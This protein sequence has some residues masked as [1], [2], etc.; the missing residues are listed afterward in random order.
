VAEIFSQKLPDID[1]DGLIK[2][3]LEKVRQSKSDRRIQEM[4][5]KMDKMYHAGKK[6]EAN[7]IFIEIKDM[8]KKKR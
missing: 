4:I 7:R 3:S 1:V 2:S 6:E 5:E 8:Q